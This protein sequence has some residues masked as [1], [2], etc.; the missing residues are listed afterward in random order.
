[1]ISKTIENLCTARYR[2]ISV[3]KDKLTV[4]SRCQPTESR[5]HYRNQFYIL[6]MNCVQ[7]Y[8]ILKLFNKLT[9]ALSI[10]I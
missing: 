10:L 2:S 7:R 3:I 4:F 1:M 8:T 5:G 9:P 6:I